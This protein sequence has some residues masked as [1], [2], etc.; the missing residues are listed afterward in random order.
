MKNNNIH[1][2]LETTTGMSVGSNGMLSPHTM[3]DSGRSKP[4]NF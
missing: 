3:L 4:S 2:N 1:I